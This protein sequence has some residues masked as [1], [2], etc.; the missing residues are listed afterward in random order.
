MGY[1]VVSVTFGTGFSQN[2]SVF[3]PCPFHHCSMLCITDCVLRDLFTEVLNETSKYTPPIR[4][5]LQRVVLLIYATPWFSY[6]PP[7]WSSL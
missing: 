6:Y 2:I 5:I 4:I 7:R 3:F 1:V